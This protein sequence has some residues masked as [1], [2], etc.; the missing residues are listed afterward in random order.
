MLYILRRLDCRCLSEFQ[1]CVYANPEASHLLIT[2][3]DAS[4]YNNGRL[5]DIISLH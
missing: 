2:R 1:P 4:L 3:Y 5:S